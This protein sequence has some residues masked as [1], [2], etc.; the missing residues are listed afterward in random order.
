MIDLVSRPSTTALAIGN[1]RRRRERTLLR[2]L[3]E[4]KID[5]LPPCPTK[6]LLL[7]MRS[8]ARRYLEETT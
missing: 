4:A 7:D 1:L 8:R 3:A 5:N 6:E 2:E